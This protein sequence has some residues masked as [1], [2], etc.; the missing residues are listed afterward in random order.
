MDLENGSGTH[1]RCK[2]SADTD[3]TTNVSFAP[4]LILIPHIFQAT[5]DLIENEVKVKD[6]S[7]F[8]SGEQWVYMKLS[9]NNKYCS[10]AQYYRG[11]LPYV[12]RITPFIERD[13]SHPCDHWN[14][15]MKRYWRYG[16]SHKISLMTDYKNS[17]ENDKEACELPTNAIIMERCDDKSN[18][19]VENV[20]PLEDTP[21]KSNR[22]IFLSSNSVQACDHDYGG[23]S[24]TVT[25]VI[26]NM[27]QSINPGDWL[28]SGGP[29]GMGRT[30]V[31]LHDG[32]FDASSGYKHAAHFHQFLLY[33]AHSYNRG[34]DTSIEDVKSLEYMVLIECD[35]GPDHNLTFLAN[36]LSLLG[37]LLVGN[38]EKINA[39]CGCPG[40]SYLKEEE[41]PTSLPNY[42][43][44][45]LALRMD[46]D[47][48]E[49]LHEIFNSV[50][51]MKG[52]CKSITKYNYI[53][54]HAI[55][56]LERRLA[57]M[58]LDEDN[59][60]EGDATY[61]NYNDVSDDT[62]RSRVGY[63]LQKFFPF[64][65]WFDGEVVRI[66][67]NVA[68]SIHV[69]YNDG[70]VEDVTRDKLDTID[71]EGSIGIG[72]I[73]FKFINFLA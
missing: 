54:T 15:D 52:V 32:I 66:M 2:S 3:T 31:S 44:E 37:L 30:F 70:D 65:G 63:K 61:A 47:T 51:S 24:K 56:A 67:P 42:G 39:T 21:R 16:M 68:K 1:H 72:E 28:Y 12:R 36:H 29:D 45:S 26:H 5:I 35:D 9:P 38:M 53:I 50:S 14:S 27:N 69:R 8:V 10:R 6:T 7:F 48:P 55:D 49:W 60:N 4:V 17:I 20:I 43:L 58:E 41:I 62:N 19:Q 59:V 40:L 25:S 57:R 23:F 33:L 34:L 71:N 11:V 22:A 18:I 46:P 13:Y 64:Y 73:G